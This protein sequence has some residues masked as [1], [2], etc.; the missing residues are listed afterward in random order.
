[1]NRS[2]LCEIK[3]MNRLFFFYQRPA[4]AIYDKGWFQNTDSRTRTKILFFAPSRPN[5]AQWMTRYHLELLYSVEAHPAAC[6]MFET[7][8]MFIR[9]TNKPFFM[10]PSYN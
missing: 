2:T 1:M 3:Y 7:E 4:S 6:A 9:R 5:Y 8:A 10:T